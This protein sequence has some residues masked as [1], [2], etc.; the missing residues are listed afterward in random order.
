MVTE[1]TRRGVEAVA[2][3]RWPVTWVSVTHIESRSC[4]LRFGV[5]Q[6]SVGGLAN[7]PQGS[8]VLCADAA[9]NPRVANIA[10]DRLPASALPS[11]K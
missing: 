11:L 3:R 2:G 6:K 7:G 5:L 8:P 1:G 4:G 9:A 10:N